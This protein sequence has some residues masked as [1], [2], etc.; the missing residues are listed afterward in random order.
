M[1]MTLSPAA[2]ALAAALEG[3]LPPGAVATAADHP[4]AAAQPHITVVAGAATIDLLTPADT[5]FRGATA[6]EAK[7]VELARRGVRLHVEIDIYAGSLTLWMPGD[8]GMVSAGRG[9]S[10][11]S[12]ALGHAMLE[13]PGNGVLRVFAPGGRLVAHFDAAGAKAAKIAGQTYDAAAVAATQAGATAP[14]VDVTEAVLL[15]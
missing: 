13:V 12:E 3:L 14:M 11:T 5:T 8:G 4:A 9:H 2:V 15:K 10:F 7:R 1:S 6:L